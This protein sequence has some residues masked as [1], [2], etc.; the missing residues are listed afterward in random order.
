M[1]STLAE[2]V[3]KMNIEMEYSTRKS[4]GLQLFLVLNFFP[5]VSFV[6]P[7]VILTT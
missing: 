3:L 7:V 1:V 4:D 2:Q 6:I 5:E